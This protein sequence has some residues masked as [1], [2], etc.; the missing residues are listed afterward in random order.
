MTQKEAFLKTPKEVILQKLRNLD[1]SVKEE[2]H[3]FLKMKIPKFYKIFINNLHNKDISGNMNGSV[4]NFIGDGDAESID[5]LISVLH[6]YN[7]ILK[8]RMSNFYLKKE[9]NIFFNKGYEYFKHFNSKLCGKE[10]NAP[11]VLYSNVLN[12]YKSRHYKF[13][14]KFYNSPIF[15][16]NIL[17]CTSINQLLKC[18]DNLKQDQTIN[19]KQKQNKVILY[20]QNIA[21]ISDYL[22][23]QITMNDST[24]MKLKADH[25]IEELKKSHEYK[26]LK[27]QRAYDALQK[28]QLE[29][30]EMKE[31]EK[32]I[33]ISE[34]LLRKEEEK[35]KE[36]IGRIR[37][38][39]MESK[40][41]K[42]ESRHIFKHLQSSINTHSSN[43]SPNIRSIYN[44]N[45]NLKSRNNLVINSYKEKKNCF[46]STGDAVN[47]I[48][49]NSESTLNSHNNNTNK[50]SKNLTL[51]KSLFSLRNHYKTSSS[52]SGIKV[53]NLFQRRK[54]LADSNPINNLGRLKNIK[55]TV[56]LKPILL[57]SV[58]EFD[59]YYLR[60]RRRVSREGLTPQNKYSYIH[61]LSKNYPNFNNKKLLKSKSQLFSRRKSKLLR[62]YEGLKVCKYLYNDSGNNSKKADV[63]LKDYYN[64]DDGLF[65]YM[66]RWKNNM[67]LYNCFVGVKRKIKEVNLMEEIY[68]FYSFLIINKPHELPEKPSKN[69]EK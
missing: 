3:S 18:C 14:E 60:E 37:V 29:R 52:I 11:A 44:Y 7:K 54:S 10:A 39:S 30:E 28:F 61:S 8:K 49:E 19:Y 15:N 26:S 56:L 42:K 50:I 47:S 41:D 12:K 62:T 36:I 2:L 4:R 16:Q 45:E 17:F 51:T 6:E 63:L 59:K 9:E 31:N 40:E 38:K 13:D 46:K 48:Q 57:R 24:S 55:T 43:I 32:E 69:N 58:K 1:S 22:A 5:E 33:K 67:E 27:R 21:N 25:N 23:D 35:Y 65:G 66:P 68:V 20:L 34:K 64:N 53:N